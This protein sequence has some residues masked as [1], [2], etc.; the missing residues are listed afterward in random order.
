M[1]LQLERQ[2]LEALIAPL[3]KQRWP[4]AADDAKLATLYGELRRVT[5]SMAQ[6]NWENFQGGASVSAYDGPESGPDDSGT[7]DDGQRKAAL[8]VAN[9]CARDLKLPST[10]IAWH[11]GGPLGCAWPNRPDAI[12]LSDALEGDALIGTVAHE[13][14][15]CW[16]YNSGV[17]VGDDAGCERDAESYARLI[18]ANVKIARYTGGGVGLVRRL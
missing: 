7:P 5:T 4:D 13:L 1:E 8:L 16:Q 2:R 12:S 10:A 11:R 17:F 14:R 15:H 9:Y 6:R 18:L 3:A